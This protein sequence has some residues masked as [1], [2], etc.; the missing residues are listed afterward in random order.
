MNYSMQSLEAIDK[1]EGCWDCGFILDSVDK[2]PKLKYS[3]YLIQQSVHEMLQ[4][5]YVYKLAEILKM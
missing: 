5:Y 4:K 3:I 1:R 2:I